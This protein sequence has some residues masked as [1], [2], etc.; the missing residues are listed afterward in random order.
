[1]STNQVALAAA[2]VPRGPAEPTLA[3]T[4]AAMRRV[5]SKRFGIDEPDLSDHCGLSTLGLDS[6]AF[7]EYTF[8]LENQLRITLPDV[9]RELSTVGDLA[10]F[11]HTE[12]LKQTVGR[13]SQ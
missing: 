13:E 7:I 11:V 4:I 9:P 3:D 12:V 1:M 6:L 2:E 10:R 5:L 8:E